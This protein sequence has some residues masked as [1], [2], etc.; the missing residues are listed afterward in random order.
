MGR[1]VT[2]KAEW[3]MKAYQVHFFIL[4]T[5]PLC[6]SCLIFGGQLNSV[7]LKFKSKGIHPFLSLKF[8]S[9]GLIFI[10]FAPITGEMTPD[11]LNQ[12]INAYLQGNIEEAKYHLHIAERDYPEKIK[13]SPE[14]YK[15]SG[16]LD[17][18]GGNISRGLS[19]LESGNKIKPD[20]GMQYFMGLVRFRSFYPA[21]SLAYFNEY[22]KSESE[23]D[24]PLPPPLIPL[25]CN[26]DLFGHNPT[27]NLPSLFNDPEYIRRIW[28]HKGSK[29]E[30]ALAQFIVDIYSDR[31]NGQNNRS[32]NPDNGKYE[33]RRVKNPFEFGPILGD[34]I[35]NPGDSGPFEECLDNLLREYSIQKEK[36]VQKELTFHIERILQIRSRIRGDLRSTYRMGV[37]MMIMKKPL[38]ALHA[39]RKALHLTGFPTTLFQNENRDWLIP[40]QI[41][42]ELESV[43]NALGRKR[44][45]R[46]A[47]EISQILKSCISAGDCSPRSGTDKKIT[48]VSRLDPVN[49]EANLILIEHAEVVNDSNAVNRY[50]FLLKK[51][52]ESM[53][54][55][56]RLDVYRD[57][58]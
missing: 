58:P 21:R 51:R 36:H 19:S 15:L 30:R 20:P 9:I 35:K 22:L 28:D 11:R 45:S 44:D 14:Y 33:T 24:Q 23:E 55:E 12:A 10:S 37:T 7:K 50:G 1:V 38:R 31:K 5:N 54:I 42:T 4:Q 49:R 25:T 53:G 48:E 26:P 8:W 32:E 34:I 3:I 56:E 57:Y 18:A 46:I 47:H 16:F 52:D 13:S 6:R 39:F 41:F 43:Y 2:G 29:S 27:W 40:L 17:I